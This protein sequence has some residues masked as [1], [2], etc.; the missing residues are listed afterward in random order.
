[1]KRII[2]LLLCAL[3]LVTALPALA[4]QPKPIPT[5]SIEEI[6]GTPAGVI[7]Y[8]LL[9]VD[10]WGSKEDAAQGGAIDSSEDAEETSGAAVNVDSNYAAYIDEIE[11]A[12]QNIST[13]KSLGNTDGMILV[14]VD[15]Y[16]N[17]VVLTSFIRDALVQ[18]PD[19]HIGRINY[20]AKN[21]SPEELCSVI[22]RH[23]G[24]KVEK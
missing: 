21:Y 19:G 9:C 23:I 12:V 24:V 10:S 13:P 14:T 1:M 18:R 3:M 22:S 5:L 20:I 6:P 8:L 7:N 11:T 16:L 17:R 15:T 4:D 2:S